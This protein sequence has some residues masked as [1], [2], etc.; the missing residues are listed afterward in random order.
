[1]AA[2]SKMPSPLR[3]SP[4]AARA[5]ASRASESTSSSRWP[6]PRSSSSSA[7][8]R[9]SAT[10]SGERRLQGEHRGPGEE[11]SHD[12]EARILGRG[13]DQDDGATLHVGKKSVL[14]RLV[15]PV[16]LVA[17][18]DRASVRGPPPLLRLLDDLP[19]P[20]H[21]LGDGRERHERGVR[22]VGNQSGQRRL[23]AARRSPEDHTP[24]IARLD[25]GAQGLSVPEDV[26][27]ASKLLQRSGAHAGR[28]GSVGGGLG[29]GISRR[30]IRRRLSLGKQTEITHGLRDPRQTDPTFPKENHPSARA[31]RAGPGCSSPGAPARAP[32]KAR[33]SPEIWAPG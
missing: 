10:S 7:E 2:V 8:R 20:R 25:H 24:G 6:R 28:E 14:L 5:M 3:A 33:G 32:A 11:R 1:M 13:P 17:E 18:E 9:I 12:L 21:A 19:H 26:F 22:P 16:D 31:P 27:M 4:S 30:R 15:E 23:S 29:S